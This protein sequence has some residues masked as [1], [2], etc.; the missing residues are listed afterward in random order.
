MLY[1]FSSVTQ[2]CPT[3]YNPMDFSTPSLPVHHQLLELAQTHVHQMPSNH[4]ILCHP[5]L[6]PSIFPSVR[7][8]SKESV[9]R[10]KWPTYWSFNFKVS[11]F[12][13]YWGLIFISIDWCDLLSVQ[14]TLKSL[15]QHRST[16]ASILQCSAF[17][18]VQLSHL[19]MTTRKTTALT[20]WNFVDKVMSLLFNM[21]S[22]LVIT[23]HPRS[24]CPLISWLQLPS[25]VSPLPPK[26]VSHCFCCFPSICHEVM[27]LDAMIF[28]FLMLS[29]KPTFPLS[30]FIFIN[31]LFSSSLFSA[32]GVV[33]SVYLRYWYFSQQSWF[34]LVLHPAQ[35]FALY[36]LH[37]S[38]ISRV[39]IYSLDVLLFQFGTCLLFH[40]WF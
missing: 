31:K 18:V 9:L 14:G 10:I 2:L 7:V 15:L 6:L 17:F 30:F 1:Q 25:S 19:Y 11:P 20:R 8:F 39:A 38:Y 34:Q 40:V 21:L 23:L 27:K 29:L 26:K 32:I 22:R 24:K 5:L 37:I 12:N 13:E 36:T 28:I 4:L 16:K 35:H 3:L 33:S